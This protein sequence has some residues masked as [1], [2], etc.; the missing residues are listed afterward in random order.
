M[1]LDRFCKSVLSCFGDSLEHVIVNVSMHVENHGECLPIATGL[2][3]T[4]NLARRCLALK[5]RR[6]TVFLLKA[7]HLEPML[8]SPGRLLPVRALKVQAAATSSFYRPIL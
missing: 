5:F 1:P 3:Q 4:Q 8:Q 6:G 2:D 7:C